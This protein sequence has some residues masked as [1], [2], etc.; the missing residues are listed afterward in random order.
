[1][2]ISF[3]LNRWNNGNNAYIKYRLTPMNQAKID[4]MK[5]FLTKIDKLK[6]AF[7]GLSKNVI[8]L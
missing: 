5:N 7:I 2:N 8:L 1:M 4:S 3:V 6:S